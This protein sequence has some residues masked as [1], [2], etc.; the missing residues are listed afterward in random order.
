MAYYCT[1]FEDTYEL[2]HPYIKDINKRYY[3]KQRDN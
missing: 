1:L 3:D 2:Y